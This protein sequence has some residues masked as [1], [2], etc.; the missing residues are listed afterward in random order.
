LDFLN[1]KKTYHYKLKKKHKTIVVSGA[2]S[3][4]KS[5]LCEWLSR[6]FNVP[7][8]PEFAR[9]YVENLG[10]HY[11][12]TDVETIARIQLQQ[13]NSFKAQGD[14]LLIADT[15]L[16]I[17]KIWF[18][19]V[20][21]QVPEWIEPAIQKEKINLFLVCDV[22]LPWVPDKVRENGGVRRNYLQSRYIDAIERYGFQY[23]IIRGKNHERYWNAVRHLEQHG[24]VKPKHL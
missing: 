17:T 21:K 19:E 10:R 16:I 2:E 12:Y 8:I 14:S 5:A 18:E 13:F 6:Y 4:G 24:I 22:D 1:G 3:T 7:C 9:E 15:W 23:E 20:F 11:E